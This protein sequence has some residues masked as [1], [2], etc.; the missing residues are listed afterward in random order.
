VVSRKAAQL[1]QFVYVARYSG[2]NQRFS[3]PYLS[4]R[5]TVRCSCHSSRC[6]KSRRV[7]G[8]S[9]RFHLVAKRTQICEENPPFAVLGPVG[10]PCRLWQRFI[11][12]SPLEVRVRPLWTTLPGGAS[13]QNRRNPICNAL[14]TPYGKCPPGSLRERRP[15]H[16]PEKTSAGETMNTKVKDL[17]VR[18]DPEREEGTSRRSF[19]QSV[20][21][22]G[23][24]G[25]AGTGS[26]NR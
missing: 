7:S 1:K 10:S 19:L 15:L 6:K 14:R 17:L 23:A 12:C 25:A 3:L 20:A 8:D 11:E 21:I 22:A 9:R 2:D 5:E 18:G 26:R 24:L 13:T 16:F 4:L